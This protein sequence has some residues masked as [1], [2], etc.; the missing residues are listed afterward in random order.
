MPSVKVAAESAMSMLRSLHCFEP[1]VPRLKKAPL[2]VPLITFQPQLCAF[3]ADA[4]NDTLARLGGEQVDDG[5][6]LLADLELVDARCLSGACSTHGQSWCSAATA[7][8]AAGAQGAF[9][10]D[11]ALR[12]GARAAHT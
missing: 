11:L 4:Q 10:W 9:E 12:A 2:Q 7:R 1:P 8:G 5:P 3:S 6:G